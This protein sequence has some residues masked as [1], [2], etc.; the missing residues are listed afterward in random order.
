MTKIEV[1]FGSRDKVG[2]QT[3][4]GVEAMVDLEPRLSFCTC[5]HGGYGMD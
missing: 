5:V 3:Q 4:V 1:S 2:S